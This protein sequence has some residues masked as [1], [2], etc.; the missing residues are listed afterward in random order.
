[1][2]AGR[3]VL[4]ASCEVAGPGIP[5]VEFAMFTV[6]P[7]TATATEPTHEPRGGVLLL[8]V[9]AIAGGLSW[10]LRMRWGQRPERMN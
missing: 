9:A 5:S 8:V 2:P 3:Y 4:T 10:Q 6:I 7:D 1:M